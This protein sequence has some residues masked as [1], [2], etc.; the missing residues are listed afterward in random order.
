MP[1]AKSLASLLIGAAILSGGV[2]SASAASAAEIGTEAPRHTFDQAKAL[3]EAGAA[4]LKAVGPDKAF[5][6]FNDPKGQ[7]VQ[8]DLYL[9]AFDRKGVYRATGF[10][11]ERTG[12][13]AWEMTDP[14]GL[15]VVQE[16]V[17]KARRDGAATV[18]YL[19][20][21]PATGKLENKTSYVVQAGDYAVGA[22]FYHK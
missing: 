22:G 9:F 11:P 5:A 15:K 14:A 21:N 8:G 1:F 17:K 20:K 6:D 12:Q 4:H 7:W 13:N 16:I 19:W 3:V 2:V 10:R 18:D